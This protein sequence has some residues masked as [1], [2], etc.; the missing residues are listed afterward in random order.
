[1]PVRW[2]QGRVP[3]RPTIPK[4]AIPMAPHHSSKGH[5]DGTPSP[6]HASLLNPRTAAGDPPRLLCK[7]LLMKPRYY[8]APS[9]RATEGSRGISCRSHICHCRWRF[10][11]SLRSLGMTYQESLSSD[12]T[13]TKSD[14]QLEELRP[15][16]A[17]VQPSAIVGLTYPRRC[18]IVADAQPSIGDRLVQTD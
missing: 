16:S 10:L 12:E 11:D 14:P 15:L 8:P 9:F 6:G 5:S 17:G 13:E 4:R 7:T 18:G 3:R 2:P 1:M